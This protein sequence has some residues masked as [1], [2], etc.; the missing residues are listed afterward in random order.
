MPSQIL[1]FLGLIVNVA[2]SSQSITKLPKTHHYIYGSEVS[3]ALIILKKVLKGL[4]CVL[5][6]MP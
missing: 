4:Y 5:C 2:D 3:I 6:E 1:N